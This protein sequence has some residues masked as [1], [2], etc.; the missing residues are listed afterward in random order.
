MATDY[1]SREAAIEQ[2]RA[3][4]DEKFENGVDDACYIVEHFVP[5]AD[6]VEVVRCK[7]CKWWAKSTNSAQGQCILSNMLPTGEYY[8]GSGRKRDIECGK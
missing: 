4:I 8:C 2:I 3:L 6:V 7:D 1:I 5:A